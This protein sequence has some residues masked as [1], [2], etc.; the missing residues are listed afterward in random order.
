MPIW[1]LFLQFEDGGRILQASVSIVLCVEGQHLD[2]GEFVGWRPGVRGTGYETRDEAIQ[3]CGYLRL[4]IDPAPEV[5]EAGIHT[6]RK[7]LK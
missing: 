1:A 7:R 2:S 5:A 4:G 3:S 6:P